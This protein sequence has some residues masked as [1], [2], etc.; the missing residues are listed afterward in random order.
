MEE[1]IVVALR[2][3]G[4][5]APPKRRRWVSGVAAA[6]ALIACLAVGAML[7]RS[8]TGGRPEALYLLALHSGDTYAPAA[9]GVRASEY[10]QWARG[11][12]EAV[13]DG[14]EL[15][16]H[17]LILGS[18]SGAKSPVSGYFI[19]RAATAEEAEAIARTVPH[20][21]YGGTV[22]VRRIVR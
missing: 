10:G 13:V 20:L 18:A 3:E 11:R 6:A 21:R 7:I 19:I 2:R 9:P 17:P 15:S 12:S 1:R 14:A 16:G 8:G 4:L 22:V 5:I